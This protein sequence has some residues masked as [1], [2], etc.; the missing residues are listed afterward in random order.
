MSDLQQTNNDNQTN[1]RKRG[2]SR[3]V[4]TDDQRLQGHGQE[5]STALQ[6]SSH[7]MQLRPRTNLLPPLIDSSGSSESTAPATTQRNPETSVQ[8]E[9]LNFRM[10]RFS[11]QANDP[12]IVR[13]VPD[14]QQTHRLEV[15]TVSS[16]VGRRIVS[17][18]TQQMADFTSDNVQAYQRSVTERRNSALHPRPSSSIPP[19]GP[20]RETTIAFSMD[21][22]SRSLDEYEVIDVDNDSS[23]TDNNTV[24]DTTQFRSLGS[25]MST[26]DFRRL[27]SPT[28]SEE[29]ATARHDDDFVD[30]MTRRLVAA[31]GADQSRIE[32]P[33]TDIPNA[34]ALVTF[35]PPAN[36]AFNLASTLQQ[37]NRTQLNTRAIN[38]AES[39]FREMEDFMT[40]IGSNMVNGLQRIADFENFVM[41]NARETGQQVHDMGQQVNDL[42]QQVSTMGQQ[43]SDIGQQVNA[44]SQQ[45]STQF[46]RFAEE[47]KKKNDENLVTVQNTLAQQFSQIMGTLQAIPARVSAAERSA[48]SANQTANAPTASLSTITGNTTNPFIT[49]VTNTNTS[50]QTSPPPQTSNSN[51]QVQNQPPQQH[52]TSGNQQYNFNYKRSIRLP[53]YSGSIDGLWSQHLATCQL[54]LQAHQCPPNMYVSEIFTTCT[55]VAADIVRDMAIKLKEQNVNIFD[56]FYDQFHRETV[57]IVFDSP[58][59]R[60]KSDD[61]VD[62]LR[63]AENES[64]DVW[65]ARARKVMLTTTLSSAEQAVKLVNRSL[66]DI[67]MEIYRKRK[68]SKINMYNVLSEL[69]T[70]EHI[71]NMATAKH[72]S[73]PS[74]STTPV[75]HS[76][77]SHSNPGSRS[78]SYDRRPNSRASSPGRQWSEGCF[79][80]KQTGHMAKDCPTATKSSFQSTKPPEQ[81]AEKTALSQ[82]QTSKPKVDWANRE[83]KTIIVRSSDAESENDMGLAKPSVAKSQ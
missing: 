2:A 41:R 21:T 22:L 37:P 83:K 55:G 1:P 34:T 49:G 39:R 81:Q 76:Y 31:R 45:V 64:V 5:L 44:M 26:D 63:Q 15:A 77:A 8:P 17:A 4:N 40:N 57:G 3:A 6:A 75:R 18:S 46:T 33:Q 66:P 78:N 68:M 38:D 65:F 25:N 54:L 73:R 43:F 74:R 36:R 11:V 72:S 29:A 67:K 56:Y 10:S 27:L 61:L 12:A 28:P 53:K 59:D 69:K 80:C 14:G 23:S 48:L 24:L 62:N 13:N 30:D 58:L 79:N 70:A 82:S 20:R 16:H 47:Q 52:H 19:L 35:T 50:M 51:Q 42:G 71:V 7:A 9:I 32:G 60:Y